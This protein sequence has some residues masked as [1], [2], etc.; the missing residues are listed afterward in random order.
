MKLLLLFLSSGTHTVCVYFTQVR[1]ITFWHLLSCGKGTIN[2]LVSM[3]KNLLHLEYNK[4][5]AIVSIVGLY[6]MGAHQ[7]SWI[8]KVIPIS[9]LD[10]CCE[11]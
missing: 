11:R 3:S 4:L 10:L 2:T 8:E 6:M 7:L 5:K 9:D 1:N